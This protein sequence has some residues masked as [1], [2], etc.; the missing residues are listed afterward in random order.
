MEISYLNELISPLALGLALVIGF[1]VK[2]AIR[3]ETINHFIPIICAV[4]GLIVVAC[5]DIPAGVFGVASVL[6]GLISGL[7]A[8]GLFEAFRNM[9]NLSN[10]D[11]V[12]ESDD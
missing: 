10:P 7:A 5:I 4:I 6:Q 1:L 8:T 12:G 3:N 2:Y 11:K 9:F